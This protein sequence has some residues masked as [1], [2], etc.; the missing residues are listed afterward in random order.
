[1]YENH[2]G[3]PPSLAHAQVSRDAD[4]MLP[5]VTATE[6]TRKPQVI[7]VAAGVEPVALVRISMVGKGALTAA[8]RSPRQKSITK[9]MAYAKTPLR[10][11]V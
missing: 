8:S 9:M 3:S 2:A 7:A 6:I 11:M 4:A 5:S 10:A 1:M